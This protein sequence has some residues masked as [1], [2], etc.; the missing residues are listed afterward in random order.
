MGRVGVEHGVVVP[1][2]N[3]GVGVRMVDVVDVGVAACAL[4]AQAV[5]PGVREG[6]WRREAGLREHVA[7]PQRSVW[8]VEGNGAG[9]KIRMD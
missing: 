5:G 8:V 6:G 1:G 7:G 9:R 2:V 3:V 4:G